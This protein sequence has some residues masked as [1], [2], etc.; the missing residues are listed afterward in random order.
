VE[1]TF[2][3]RA[4]HAKKRLLTLI[5]VFRNFFAIVP[6]RIAIRKLLTAAP[7]RAEERPQSQQI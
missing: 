4:L 5:S 7:A 3:Q 6:K 1:D 2:D